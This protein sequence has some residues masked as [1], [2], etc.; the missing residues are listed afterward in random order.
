MA[1]VM[2]RA[3]ARVRDMAMA[4]DMFKDRAVARVRAMAWVKRTMARDWAMAMARVGPG[5]WLRTWP[6]PIAMAQV[7]AKVSPKA[8]ARVRIRA[9]A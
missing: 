3:V 6:G 7:I 2:V 4:Y 1:K 5:Q 8:V 9:M